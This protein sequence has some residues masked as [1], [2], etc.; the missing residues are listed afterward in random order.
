MTVPGARLRPNQS[1]TSSRDSS[2]YNIAHNLIVVNLALIH[3]DPGLP[4]ADDGVSHHANSEVVLIGSA[5]PGPHYREST[6]LPSDR[7]I[8]CMSVRDQSNHTSGGQQAR[9]ISF[10]ESSDG[11]YYHS[12]VLH[13]DAVSMSEGLDGRH[14]TKPHLD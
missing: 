12:H 8:L 3:K 4:I 2:R 14:L 7:T 1:D 13:F 6:N 10:Y 11:H 9:R 5:S